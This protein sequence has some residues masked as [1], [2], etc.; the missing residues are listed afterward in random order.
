MATSDDAA[1]TDTA[2]TTDRDP[3]PIH[4]VASVT[5]GAV[6]SFGALSAQKVLLF[7]F[8]FI[9]TQSFSVRLYGVYAFGN[10]F[11]AILTGFVPLGS[12][13]TIVRFL[14]KYADD[15]QRQNRVL[16]LAYATTI[17][18]S[19]GFGACL[20]LFAPTLNRLTLGEPLLVDVLRLFAVL[21]TF[22][23]LITFISQYFRTL[24]MVEYH[25]LILYVAKPAFRLAGAGVAIAL[26][27]SVLGV[28]GALTAATAVLT[29]IILWAAL[30]KTDPR[31][32][33][34]ATRSE[35]CEYY[36]YSLP[37]ALA[38]VGGILRSRIDV[39]LVGALLTASD[40]G[41]YNIV[42]IIVTVLAIPLNAFNQILP[43]V[44]SQLYTEENYA[45]LEDVYSTITRYVFTMTVIGAIIILVYRIELLRI[46]GSEYTRGGVVLAVFLVGRIIANACG[47]TGWLL[48]MTDHQYLH[49]LNNWVLAVANVALSYLFIVEFGLIGAAVGTGG[50]IAVANILRL[51]ELWYLENLQPF[52][53]TFLKP[54][55]AGVFAAIV[56]KGAG[57]VLSGN[58]LLIVGSLAG[59]VTFASSLYLLGI[60]PEDHRLATELT[61]AYGQRGSSSAD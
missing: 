15:P 20:F 58:V 46:F 6:V 52:D 26:G 60:E 41:I 23:T 39:V 42:L 24:K 32:A 3:D 13:T 17:A 53:A 2:S 47:A 57:M 43:P 30:T 19:I 38:V 8:N 56:M 27:Y 45:A 14:P 37:N 21:L 11:I 7:A 1:D 51:T 29:V 61:E 9:L 31:P 36:N 10:R 12:Q 55:V 28:V 18:S 48:L 54:T 16:G 50:A 49:M 34:G 5:H 4:E 33:V 35:I 22:N 25:V 59:V 40:A 44:A